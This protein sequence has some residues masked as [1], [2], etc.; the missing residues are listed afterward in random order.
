MWRYLLTLPIGS[1]LSLAVLEK[2][3]AH[4]NL[5]SEVPEL[6]VPTYFL[7]GRHDR[8]VYVDCAREYFEALQAP[9]KRWVWFERSAHSPTYEEPTR[10]VDVM[11]NQVLPETLQS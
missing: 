10:F 3:F 9:R 8:Q 1:Y 4:R 5:M 6:R 11:V 7:E 2:E